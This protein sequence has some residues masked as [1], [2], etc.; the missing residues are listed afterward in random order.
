MS[1]LRTMAGCGEHG[2]GVIVDVLPPGGR[3]IECLGGIGL[4]GEGE[5][6]PSASLPS[7]LTCQLCSRS[8]ESRVPGRVSDGERAS[9]FVLDCIVRVYRFWVGSASDCVDSEREARVLSDYVLVSISERV[10]ILDR[11]GEQVLL[12]SVQRVPHAPC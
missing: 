5:E 11:D 3:S 8:L 7:P 6:R 4:L 2:P 10:P 1:S 9:F 12:P